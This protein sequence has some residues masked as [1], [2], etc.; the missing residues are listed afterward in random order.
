MAEILK[1]LMLEDST[2]EA[3]II[4]RMLI[5]EKPGIEFNL[6]LDKDA[7]LLALDQ[8]NPGVILADNSMPQFSA[9]EALRIVHQR[10]LRIPFIMVT[11]T[12]S[13]EFAADIIKSGADDYILKDR[14]IR[15][16][17]AIDAA[18]KQQRA[19]KEKRDALE[20]IRR[21]NERFQT[22]S[23]ATKDAV[24]DWDLLT[25]EI[26]WNEN[27]FNLM[28]FNKDLPVPSF[29]EWTQRIHPLDR[30]RVLSRLGR[31]RKNI[32]QSW[33]DE[34][35]FQLAD[36]SYGTALDRA[37]VMKDD[38]G[39]PVRVIGALVDITEQKRLM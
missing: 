23:R 28:R 25:D 10:S 7:F 29:I 3:E 22:L 27:F 32:I 13:E 30:D 2:T 8:F 36:G 15:L 18:L 31:M 11:G 21:S 17:A 9:G 39:N 38:I 26:W 34:F 6:A 1:I 5:K 33:G 24:W 19:E 20:G 4:Q 37:Y 35:R 12:V 14:L 16:P